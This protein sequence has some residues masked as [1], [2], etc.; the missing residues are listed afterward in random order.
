MLVLSH[1]HQANTRASNHNCVGKPLKGSVRVWVARVRTGVHACARTHTNACAHIHLLTHSHFAA[2]FMLSS[3]TVALIGLP[4]LLQLSQ[5]VLARLDV[6]SKPLYL[7]SVFW[8]VQHKH[9]LVCFITN[10][11]KHTPC[12][13]KCKKTYIVHFENASYKC[14]GNS[15][16]ILIS[17]AEVCFHW[18]CVHGICWLLLCILSL[19]L[20]SWEQTGPRF[21]GSVWLGVPS[22][23]AQLLLP[24]QQQRPLPS[25]VW[26]L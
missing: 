17:R 13:N 4:L 15:I 25:E 11:S 3:A 1:K 23:R 16:C 26:L 2:P 22:I 14:L 5:I 20:L 7:I 24:M 8:W 10:T 19:S 21:T 12:T 9:L 18:V 6:L